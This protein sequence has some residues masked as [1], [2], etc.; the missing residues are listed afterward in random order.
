MRALLLQQG[1]AAALEGEAKLPKDMVAEKNVEILTKAHSAI[2]LTLT[3]EE[4]RE[5]TGRVNFFEACFKVKHRKVKFGTGQ[6]T[7]KEI[8]E[9]VHSDLWGPAPVKS[10]GGCSYFVKFI[11]DYSRKVWLYFLKTKDEVFGK[12]REWKTMTGQDETQEQPM[13]SSS[14]GADV[15]KD[16]VFESIAK[17]R[18]NRVI[19]KPDRYVGCVNS[20]E[21]DSIAFALATGEEIDTEDPQ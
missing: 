2:L 15:G 11:D 5:A 10:Q 19:R 14:S 4:L 20:S 9:Y 8:L 7:S 17:R 6:H 16:D 12:F 18:S 13:G 1:C 21:L 3:D